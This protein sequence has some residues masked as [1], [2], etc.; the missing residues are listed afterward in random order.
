MFHFLENYY[1]L[2][3]KES[4][5][6]AQIYG[7]VEQSP[8]LTGLPSQSNPVKGNLS[9]IDSSV[10]SGQQQMQ[11]SSASLNPVQP[12]QQMQPLGASLNQVQPVQQMQPGFTNLGK[13]QIQPPGARLNSAQQQMQS[14]GITPI[15]AQQQMQ[16]LVTSSNL[17]QKNPRFF[18]GLSLRLPSF[19]SKKNS[20]TL[21]QTAVPPAVPP[22]ITPL[23]L[24]STQQLSLQQA[25]L[26]GNSSTPLI[27]P[28]NFPLNSSLLQATNSQPLA[29]TNRKSKGFLSGLFGKR[30][31]NNRID[32]SPINSTLTPPQEPKKT[33]GEKAKNFFGI[34]KKNSTLI[35][36]NPQTNT[37]PLL[38]SKLRSNTYDPSNNNADSRQT[39]GKKIQMRTYHFQKSKKYSERAFIA[40]RPIIAA[41]NAY[42]FMKLHY[43]IGSKKV[44]F[45]IHDRVNNKKY[46][47]TARTLKDGTNVIKSAK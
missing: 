8:N 25:P 28:P 6:K 44:T 16:P 22:A 31:K 20:E 12:F 13:R 24:A 38:S 32:A 33:L 42:D 45:T 23:N 3:A 36:P 37:P 35:Q 41:D 18:S 47:Y 10:L 4:V 11:P 46:K 21:M 40:E 43:D 7:L 30:N 39:G 9:Q 5:A 34:G 29:S 27:S 19:G 14:P 2:R 1:Q 17:A 26:L 15:S